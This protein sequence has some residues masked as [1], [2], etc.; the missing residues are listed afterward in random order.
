MFSYEKLAKLHGG[1][2]P[3]NLA[4]PSAPKIGTLR[5]ARC[6]VPSKVCS[7]LGRFFFYTLDVKFYTVALL[8]SFERRKHSVKSSCNDQKRSLA[9]GSQVIP[10]M[11][12]HDIMSF[13]SITV[14]YEKYIGCY[15][16]TET[17][18]T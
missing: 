6:S 8:N 7:V 15:P 3:S 17:G 12:S 10:F 2:S 14:I 1:F 4:T 13:C 5:G 16:Y 18:T 9:M 11:T